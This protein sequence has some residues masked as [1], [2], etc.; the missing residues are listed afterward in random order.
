MCGTTETRE[1][2]GLRVSGKRWMKIRALV[3]G[4]DSAYHGGV[5][6]CEYC[7]R[8]V[9]SDP[10][11][12]VQVDHIIPIEEGGAVVD[13]SNLV[14]SCHKC[15]GSSGHWYHRKPAHIEAALLRLVSERNAAI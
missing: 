12:R 8:D 6:T 1:Q 9:A 4:R 11:M 14:T 13:L 2:Q 3:I 5:P 10:K 15:N 7:G